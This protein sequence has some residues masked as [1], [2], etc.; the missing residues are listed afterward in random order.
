ME[1]AVGRAGQV[2]AAMLLMIKTLSNINRERLFLFSIL[3]VSLILFLG[4]LGQQCLWQD[5]AQTA[6][7][8]K[9]I[10]TD[11]IPRGTDG[12][13]FFSQELGSEYGDN[14]IWKWHTWLPFY[15]LAAFYK[16]YGI[17]TFI[18]RVPFALFGISSAF[19]TYL[20]CRAI[21]EDKKIAYAAAVLLMTCVPFLILSRQCRYYSMAAFFSLW[22]LHSYIK[23]LDGKKF[24]Y[25]AFILSSTFLFHTHYIYCAPL[26][27]SVLLHALLFYRKKLLIMIFLIAIMILINIPWIIWLSGIKYRESYNRGFFEIKKYLLFQNEYVEQIRRYV[28]SPYLL[29]AVPAAA[30]MFKI[31]K[32][33]IFSG[34]S[35]YGKM[36]CLLIFFAA[37]TI[38][39]LSL[40]SPVNSFRYLSP[41]IPILIIF[42]ACLAVFTDRIHFLMP[43]AI[44]AL[45]IITSPMKNFLY[46]LTHDYRGPIDGIVKYLNE[47]GSKDDI[48]AITY[49]DMPLKFYTNMRVI[50]GLTGEDLSDAKK[51]KWVIIRKYII[52]ETDNDVRKYLLENL[53]SDDYEKIVIDYPDIPF[54]NREDP[55]AH[56]FRTFV[57]EDKVAIFHKIR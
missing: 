6:L 42:A 46:E 48:V 24:A 54:E 20:L 41:I 19:M 33:P 35:K 3:F 28:F 31:R 12:K 53:S 1:Y 15:V 21:W 43:A 14:Y 34:G 11:G 51:A 56:Q 9:T 30:I 23:I 16:L 32:Q 7:V 18:S 26:F 38:V 50:G 47:N 36:L 2:I 44:V 49:G 55:G 25:V 13:N 22:A 8:S 57:K 52:C 29:L 27:F 39:T 17:S 40:I 45:I 5:E 4:N 10:L 37:S